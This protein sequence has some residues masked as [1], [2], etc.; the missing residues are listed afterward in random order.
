MKPDKYWY[1]T[2]CK[3]KAIFICEKN[4]TIQ[5]LLAASHQSSNN[6]TFVKF[7]FILTVMAGVIGLL[8][9][10]YHRRHRLVITFFKIILQ[11]HISS[12]GSVHAVASKESTYR[13]YS[14][15]SYSDRFLNGSSIRNYVESLTQSARRAS[16]N[17]QAVLITE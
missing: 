12:F 16:T 2:L 7:W 14:L 17:D 11:F 15:R 9:V 3:S 1:V 5:S 13:S 6:L 10:G 8:Y 4:A